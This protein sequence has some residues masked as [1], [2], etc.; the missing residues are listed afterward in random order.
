MLYMEE[1]WQAWA[2]CQK[3]SKMA[4][5][6]EMESQVENAVFFVPH[7]EDATAKTATALIRASKQ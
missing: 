7:K 2:V 4:L 6:L 5:H 1:D 3:G